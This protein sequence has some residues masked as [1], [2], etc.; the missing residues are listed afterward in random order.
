MFIDVCGLG[1]GLCGNGFVCYE[2]V[3]FFIGFFIGG[4]EGMNMLCLV[5]ELCVVNFCVVDF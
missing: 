4:C 5:G 1:W 2:G 3:C